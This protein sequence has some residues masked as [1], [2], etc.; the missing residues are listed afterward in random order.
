MSSDPRLVYKLPPSGG[1]KS[2]ESS[3]IKI[4]TQK[5]KA[6][7]KSIGKTIAKGVKKVVSA[8]KSVASSKALS[9]DS[10]D[11]ETTR[12]PRSNVYQFFHPPETHI[13]IDEREYQFFKCNAPRGCKFDRSS[14]STLSKHAKRCWGEKVVNARMKEECPA[15][16]SDRTL[17]PAELRVMR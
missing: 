6:A 7:S 3:S 13:S 9:K 10:N 8:A 14:T 11:A 16:P 12:K 15:V 4:I 1:S 5:A 2:S 17:T